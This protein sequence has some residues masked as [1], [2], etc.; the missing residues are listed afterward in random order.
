MDCVKCKAA[1]EDD[2]FYCDQ[3]GGEVF[4]CT[5]ADCRKPGGPKRCMHCGKPMAAAR[6]LGELQQ[7]GGNGGKA[8]AA[9]GKLRLHS[10]SHGIDIE[11]ADGDVLGRRF[12]QHATTLSRFSQISSNHLQVRRAPDGSWRITDMNSFNGT[13]Y[14]GSRLAANQ[15]TQ[16]LDGGSL[17][18]GDID[19]Q[20]SIR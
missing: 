11:P 5:A 20:V 19:V 4:R 9:I 10:A 3:C 14:N 15:E 1:I 8:A 18:L 13:F 6:T 17:R 16:L 2:S 7:A 12:G